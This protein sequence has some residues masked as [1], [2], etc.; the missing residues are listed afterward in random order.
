[1]LFIILLFTGFIPLIFGANLLVD[2]ASALAKRLHIPVIVIGFT[3]VAFGTSAPELVVNILAS[4]EK[5]SEIT[6]GNV[7]GSNLFNILII[8][9]IAAVV[10]PHG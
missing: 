10:F 5:S 9:G 3:I 4:I 1:M 7:I 8:L 6:L 2:S